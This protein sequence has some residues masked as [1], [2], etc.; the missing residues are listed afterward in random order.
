MNL[1][2][3]FWRVWLII[4]GVTFAGITAVVAWKGF[5]DLQS[6]FRDL[7]RARGNAESEPK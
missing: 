2:A 7:S 6:M 1:W 5:A 4:S 3:E